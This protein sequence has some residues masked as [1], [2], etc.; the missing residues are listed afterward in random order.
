MHGV[1][2]PMHLYLSSFLLGE[3]TEALVSIA[4]ARKAV[5]IANALDN[6]ASVRKEH[7]QTQLDELRRLGFDAGE[8]D[9][10]AYFGAPQQL[11]K[12]LAD[13]GLVWVTGGN[14]FLLR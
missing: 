5:V 2:K 14:A 3:E 1:S 4:R 6:V 10:R 13:V 7:S 8:L 9:L 12:R 11:S